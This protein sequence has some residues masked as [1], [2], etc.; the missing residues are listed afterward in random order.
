VLGIPF[1]ARPREA[2]TGLRRDEVDRQGGDGPG[3]GDDVEGIGS[4]ET[5]PDDEPTVTADSGA[6]VAD[7]PW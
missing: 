4:L 1:D 6:D 7:T 2:E 5:A 3:P